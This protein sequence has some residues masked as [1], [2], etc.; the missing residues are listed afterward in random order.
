[1][2]EKIPYVSACDSKLL[3]IVEKL[4]KGF[5]FLKFIKFS[6]SALRCKIYNTNC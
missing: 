1:M 5:I 6:P 4:I 3:T 2:Y